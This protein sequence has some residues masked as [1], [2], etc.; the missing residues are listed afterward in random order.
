MKAVLRW[1]TGI[2]FGV[3]VVAVLDDYRTTYY[4]T[5]SERRCKRGYEN[6][7]LRSATETYFD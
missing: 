3:A 1:A 6:V 5:P 7:L 4:L 2:L